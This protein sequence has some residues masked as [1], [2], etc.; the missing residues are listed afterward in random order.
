MRDNVTKKA[1]ISL[2]ADIKRYIVRVL[3]LL[4]RLRFGHRVGLVITEHSIRLSLIRQ[5][6]HKCRVIDV[7]S[8]PLNSQE[9][10][11]WSARVDA[12]VSA[13]TEYV[14]E[15]GLRHVAVNVGL[16]GDEI[17]FRRLSL[18]PMPKKELSAAVSWEGEKLFPFKFENCLVHHRIVDRSRYRN[19]DRVGINIIAAKKVF[20]EAVY[21][22]FDA[23]GLKIGQVNF[24]PSMMADTLTSLAP[25]GDR[26]N[27]LLIFLDDN[28]SL[29]LFLRHGQPEFYQQFVTAPQPDPDGTKVQNVGALTS[30]L[31]SFLDLHDAQEG[32][33]EL[34]EVVLC[35][36]YSSDPKIRDAIIVGTDLPCRDVFEGESDPSELKYL[37]A[38]Q[39]C[40][41]FDVIAAG[42]A[43]NTLH[44]LIPVAIRNS[45]GRRR[46][47]IRSGIAVAVALLVIG[48]LHLQTYSFEKSA[49]YQAYLSLIGK[50]NHDKARLD[51]PAESR[52]SHVHLLLKELSRTVPDEITLNGIYLT[53]ENQSYVLRLE[54]HVRLSDF[55]PEIVLAQY[56]ET[57]NKSPFFDNVSVTG[58]S[59]KRED[60]RFDLSFHLQMGARV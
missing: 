57:L 4:S 29:A 59:K 38:D 5:C 52:P 11:A 50:F 54:G 15:R 12:A 56:V 30:E 9:T 28:Q 53:T 23:A 24:L 2:M 1:G 43:E 10:R 14:N 8:F 34:D 49:G 58:Y 44:P 16:A 32:E 36:K 47:L 26:R 13:A 46:L 21:D 31:L 45:I 25:N 41:H 18:P 17:A 42:L 35:G 6:L 60:N 20:V 39:K 48:N 22:R 19:S 27:S 51:N 33:Q 55:S 7:S 40:R 37:R 3:V